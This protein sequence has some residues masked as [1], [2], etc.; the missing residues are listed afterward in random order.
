M[1]FFNRKSNSQKQKNLNN[2]NV[3]TTYNSKNLDVNRRNEQKFKNIMDNAAKKY[4]SYWDMN[5]FLI[6]MV[7]IILFIVIVIGVFYYVT[8]WFNLI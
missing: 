8:S 5:N 2:E 7:L 3:D 6:K 1:G 4:D